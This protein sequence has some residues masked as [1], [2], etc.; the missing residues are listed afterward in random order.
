MPCP[1]PMHIVH[2]RAAAAAALQPERRR[3]CAARPLIPS[4][5]PSATGPAV[6]V[7]VLGVIGQA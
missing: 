4:G 7:H 1:T 3:G 6:R 2:R 5:C